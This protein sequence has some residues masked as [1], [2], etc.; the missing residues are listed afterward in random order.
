[1]KPSYCDTSKTARSITPIS[2][3][4]R[5][6]HVGMARGRACMR[7]FAEPEGWQVWLWQVGDDAANGDM[8]LSMNAPFEYDRAP[9]LYSTGLDRYR[10][11]TGQ[12]LV[13]WFTGVS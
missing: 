12:D 10:N 8:R 9:S 13:D 2:I 4:A 5:R 3:Q 11:Y 7:S 6:N 1:M